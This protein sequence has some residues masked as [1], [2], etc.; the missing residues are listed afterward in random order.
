[1]KGDTNMWIIEVIGTFGRGYE[2]DRTFDTLGE[3]E[4]FLK[5]IGAKYVE[6]RNPVS[7]CD[8]DMFWYDEIWNII[9][10]I[11]NVE[12]DECRYR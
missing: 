7:T 1:M 9:Y 4:D 10:D 5:S 12:T 3:A 8:W 11:R 2:Y 6:R